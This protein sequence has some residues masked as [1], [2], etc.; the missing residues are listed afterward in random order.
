[1][2]EEKYDAGLRVCHTLW[3]LNMYW[4]V[5]GS[6]LAC[7]MH[8][9]AC[10]TKQVSQIIHILHVCRGGSMV[11]GRH[12]GN[13]HIISYQCECTYIPMRTYVAE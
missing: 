9:R 10:T 2:A 13:V 1:M 7:I 4:M 6:R 12:D 3:E 5:S 8:C 11:E